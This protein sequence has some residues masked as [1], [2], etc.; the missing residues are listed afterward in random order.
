MDMSTIPV[1]E[2]IRFFPNELLTAD[3]L[4]TLDANSRALRWLHNSTLHNWGIAYGLDVQ[5]AA[6]D[7]SVTVNPGYANDILGREIILSS[8]YSLPIPA[9]PGA[10]DGSAVIYYVVANYVD[11]ADEA[12]VEQREA[13]ACAPGGAVRLS[14]DPAILWKT[15]AQLNNGID[16]ILGQASIQNCVLSG[17]ISTAGRRNAVAVSNFSVFAADIS[18][19]DIKWAAWKQGSLNIGFTAAIDT[20]AAKFQSTPT[21]MAQIIGPRSLSNPAVVVVDV[22]SLAN[23]SPT[24][25]TLQVAL[26]PLADGV[27]SSVITDINSGPAVMIKLGWRVT[28]VGV[29]G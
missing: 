13:T 18:A 5:G 2:R 27:N 4:T 16:V 17:K 1:L 25:F 19:A 14:N 26:P 9:V 11:D 3:D 20:T 22:V 10:S 8:T 23:E 12:T 28:W 29:E 24:G 7:T 21:Y 6:G 15:P